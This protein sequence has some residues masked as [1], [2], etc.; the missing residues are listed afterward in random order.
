[1]GFDRPC[2]LKSLK[3]SVW[4]REHTHNNNNKK[5][6]EIFFLYFSLLSY[7]LLYIGTIR[8]HTTNVSAMVTTTVGYFVF[9]FYSYLPSLLARQRKL[10]QIAHAHID[11]HTLEISPISIVVVHNNTSFTYI[12]IAVLVS[13]RFIFHMDGVSLSLSGV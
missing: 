5:L 11:K 1:M 7:V 12:G 9:I 2:V 10:N 8:K 4:E 13:I 6:E 3:K